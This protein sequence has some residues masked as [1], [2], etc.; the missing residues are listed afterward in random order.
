MCDG[1][2]DEQADLAW[3]IRAIAYMLSRVKCEPSIAAGCQRKQTSWLDP[4]D[5]EQALQLITGWTV[6]RRKRSLPS[7]VTVT[8]VES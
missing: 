7:P 2:T 3:H 4:T 5:T 8:L 1:Q 6:D